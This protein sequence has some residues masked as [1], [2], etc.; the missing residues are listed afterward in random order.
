MIYAISPVGAKDRYVVDSQVSLE[1]QRLDDN[2][3][4]AAYYAEFIGQGTSLDEID[5]YS[6]YDVLQ[7]DVMPR[8]AA[9]ECC[10]KKELCQPCWGC[11]AMACGRCIVG[12]DNPDCW[13]CQSCAGDRNQLRLAITVLRAQRATRRAILYPMEPAFVARA[14]HFSRV[15]A[16]PIA[17]LLCELPDGDGDVGAESLLCGSESEVWRPTRTSS[18]SG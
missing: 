10:G 11:R 6:L 3:G 18:S 12:E 1:Y 4:L 15:D 2:G 9:C 8:R 17:S 7:P 14:R 5:F 16:V 13:V